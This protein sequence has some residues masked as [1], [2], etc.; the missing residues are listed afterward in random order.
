[1]FPRMCSLFVL[2]FNSQKSILFFVIHLCLI[3]KDYYDRDAIDSFII[4]LPLIVVEYIFLISS[5]II[6]L[7]QF[8]I[9]GML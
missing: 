8:S 7:I 5:C 9:S 1:M 4:P 6:Y 3:N 2:G